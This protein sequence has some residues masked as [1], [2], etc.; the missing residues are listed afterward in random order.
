MLTGESVPVSKSASDSVFAATVNTT[1]AFQMKATR[2][3]RDTALAHIVRLVE[4]AAASRA[5]VARLAD[6][7]AGIFTPLVVAFAVL[8]FV[9]WI[10]LG[11]SAHAWPMAI[12]SAVSVL[13]IACPCALGLA[14]PTAIMVGTGRAASMGVLI[15]GGAALEALA[16]VNSV[17]LD[18]T[19]TITEGRPTL[20]A[21][22]AMPGFDEPQVLTAAA[23]VEQLSEHPVARAIVRAARDRSLP[24]ESPAHFHA[25]VGDG[26]EGAVRATPVIAGRVSFVQSRGVHTGDLQARA[27]ALAAQ[28]QTAVA[29]AI[30]GRAAG[31]LAVSDRERP[32]SAAAVRTLRARGID[33]CMLSGD[34]Q[35]AADA[36]A[37][38]VGIDRVVAQARPAD[39]AAFVR[40]L[41]AGGRR[42][43]MVGDG[44]NDAPALAAADVGI[45]V[46]GGTDIASHAAGVVLMGGGIGGVAHAL[47][48]GRATMRVVRQNLFWA[49]AYNVVGVPLAAGAL[50]PWLAWEPGPMLA[51]LAMS[52]SSVCVVVNS[53][54][55]R[56]T[57][58]QAEA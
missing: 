25:F 47:A 9:L 7:V 4:D 49:F 54:R 30:A 57:S 20:V 3:G 33:I 36:V 12:K 18:K 48:L 37:A 46:A 58:L 40:D 52:L 53:L 50:W 51:G 39:K 23:S 13:V 35:A 15:K 28:G 44:I 11:D 27:D 38:R 42:V 10:S 8:T 34:S 43:A 16:S 14:T 41:R 24:L 6:R 22:T 45:A 19:G 31:V 5:P 17:V 2:V 56:T 1:G 29:V 32:D 21:C 55:L 26:V